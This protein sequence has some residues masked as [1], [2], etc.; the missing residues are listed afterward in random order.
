MPYDAEIDRLP[1]F[2][3]FDLKGPQEALS[4]WTDVLPPFPTAPNTATCQGDLQLCHTGPNRWLLRAPLEREEALE[5]ALRPAEAP[6]EISIVRISD[7]LTFFRITGPDAA[8]VLSIGCPMDLHPV[9]FGEDAASFTEFF[10]LKAFVTRCEAG[11][12]C[13]VDRSFG[14]MAA[15]YLTRAMA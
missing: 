15:D 4:A 5:A 11:F 6:P 12:D 3:L 7:V 10:G 9:T 1:I 2:T 14:D 8:E 13:A